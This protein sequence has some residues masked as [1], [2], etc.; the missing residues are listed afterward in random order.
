[1]ASLSGIDLVNYL[2]SVPYPVEV[3]FALT[4][5]KGVCFDYSIL[6]QELCCALGINCYYATG[7]T[8]GVPHAWNIVEIDGV[9][10][11]VDPTWAAGKHPEQYQYFLVSD[12][13]MQ[14]D[15]TLD[16][17]NFLYHLPSCPFD[18]STS[19]SQR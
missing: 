3:N 16:M 18:Y 7:D 19:I 17:K 5:K 10:Y 14:Q 6:F 8:A 11:Q 2:Q 9:F 1:M 4:Y 13:T 12:H 15:H